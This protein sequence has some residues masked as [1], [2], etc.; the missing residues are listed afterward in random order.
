MRSSKERG[1]RKGLHAAAISITLVLLA[2]GCGGKAPAGAAARADKGPIVD[3]ILVEAKT[4]ED[5][6]IKDVAEGKSDVFWYAA[7]GATYKGLPSEVKSKLETYA[8]PSGS[9]SILF[10]PYPNKAP[11]TVRTKAG[12]TA[13]NPFAI[14]EL[15]FAMNGLINR[16]R[17]ID[18]IVSGAGQ[19]KYTTITL[20]LP[21]SG[22]YAMV[23]SKLGIT[24]T[25][26]E[27]K[28]LADI[29]AALRAAAALS[30]NRGRLEKK[31]A[32]WRFDGKEVEVNFLIRVDDP[33]GRLK[34]GRYIA[35]QIEKAGI[36]VNR[37]EYD[38][39]KCSKI[40][41]SGDPKDYE[42]NAYT[43]AWIGGQT[44]SSWDVP[45]A[46]HYAPWYTQMPGG[47]NAGQ[48][49]YENPE[50]DELTK[51]AVNGIVKDSEDYY[52]KCLRAVELGLQEA[53]RVFVVDTTNYYLANKAHFN[54]RMAYGIGDGL[55]RLSDL[56]ADVKPDASGPYKGQK[57]LRITE[58]SA[59]GSLFASAWDPIGPDGFADTY[60]KVLT[61]PSSDME[62][63]FSP[64][65]GMCMPLRANYK[66]FRAEPRIEG[67]KMLGAIPLPPEAVIW[68]ARSRK[69]ES[70]LAYV[71]K[72]EGNY[73][74][75]K[76][77]DRPEYGKAVATATFS[78]S[79]AKWHDGRMMD[80]NDYRYAI[81]LQ[82]DLCVKKGAADK[83]YEAS[84]AI[85]GNPNLV[86][87]KG[88]V[89]NKDGGITS[90]G[91]AYYPM[92]PVYNASLICPS[93][94]AQ[95]VNTQTIVGWPVLEAIMGLVAEG[96]YVVN[97]NGDYNEIDVIAEKCV[98]DIR[99][100]LEEYAASSHLPDCL[101]GYV[102]PE[103][104]AAD[105]KLAI[106]FIDAHK[107]AYISNGGFL[108]DRYDPATNS[109]TL[110]ATPFDDYPMA[111]GEMVK[112]VETNYAR[113]NSIKAGTYKKGSD[114]AVDLAVAEV[115]YPAN[116]AKAADKARVRVTLV[117][118]R[119]RVY[120]AR[121]AK[122]GIYRATIPAADLAALK[123]GTY[124]LIG[125]A[126]LGTDSGAVDTTTFMVF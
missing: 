62:F 118:D 108:I 115:A 114:L 94:L 110:V 41:R 69:W 93:L 37:L 44:Y 89:F 73:G 78:H 46:Q 3:R 18:E 56:T 116:K 39:A 74:Y 19:P 107:H 10:N 58:F 120:E 98:A 30:A 5:I 7:D 52:A 14:R 80:L 17:I 84:Y 126:S 82:Y 109:A 99:A 2:A 113:I 88:Y 124:T 81:A 95:P 75:A 27:A 4:Q 92:D 103:E 12:T 13:F 26:D 83:T 55:N 45:I 86:R 25:G 65:T 38:R 47:G 11:Y 36:K 70:G 117:A 33:N 28:A 121:E 101:K 125:E 57:V 40:Y 29:D 32:R 112:K 20:G 54:S 96:K 6:A 85:A 76:A 71:D 87:A 106:A 59:R 97:S 34:E 123:E 79:Y 48:W 50:I 67:N 104:A 21:N 60:S 43:E 100:K 63:D 61:G 53:V 16:K 42:W 66:D 31:G 119:E 64:V 49:N 102:K 1:M 122:A 8:V 23:A 91:D 72:G 9:W 77:S 111:K 15:R 22:R 68:D 90:Y 51:S 105:Y 24:E 35:D